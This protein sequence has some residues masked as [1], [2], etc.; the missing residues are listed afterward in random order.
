MDN[1]M[2]RRLGATLAVVALTAGGLTVAGCGGDS[3][4]AASTAATV[5]TTGTSTAADNGVASLSGDEILA[6]AADAAKSAD[7]V[8]IKGDITQ[9]GETIGLNLAIGKDVADGTITV[10]GQTVEVRLTNGVFYMRAPASFYESLGSQGK[11]VGA[12]VADKWF[13][14][15]VDGSS[16]SA[17]GLDSFQQFTDKE[18]L[19]S[20]LLNSDKDVTVEGSGNVD[21]QPVVLLK[22]SKGGTLAVA[23][24]G[25]A[26]PLQVTG[27]DSKSS[28]TVNFINWNGPVN[29]VAPADAVDVGKLLEAAGGGTTTATT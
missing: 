28:G 15:P 12:L 29:A 24:T 11:G 19:F 6:K 16:A 17:T 7:S 4:P 9:G 14:F 23:T 10:K 20:S 18:A 21:G 2:K 26:Y 1:V 27:S 25:E 13:S 3:A 5:A 22:S 8:T